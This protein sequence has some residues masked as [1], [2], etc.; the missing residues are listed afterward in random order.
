[1]VQDWKLHR[2]KTCFEFLA[3]DEDLEHF[4]PIIGKE[5]KEIIS[6]MKGRDDHRIFKLV[7]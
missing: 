2:E 6:D 4:S 7:W 5:W 1:M 3:G